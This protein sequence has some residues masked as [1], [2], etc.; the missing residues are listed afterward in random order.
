MKQ[1]KRIGILLAAMLLVQSCMIPAAMASDA[2]T[3]SQE[4]PYFETEVDMDDPQYWSEMY[5]GGM[6]NIQL[7]A[8]GVDHSWFNPRAL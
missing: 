7:Q 1:M 4:E 8:V 5:R 2:D 3:Y 6:D